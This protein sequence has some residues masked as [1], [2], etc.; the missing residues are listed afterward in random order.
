[1]KIADGVEMLELHLN[2][3]GREG[4][5]HPTL[6]WDKDTVILVDTGIPGQ[7]QEIREAMAN[8][9]VPF[10]RLNKIILT[11][12]D[13][14][15]FGG[16]RNILNE[17]TN[18]V[19]V[20]SHESDK[21]YI[22]GEKMLV[23]LNSKFMNRINVLPEEQR[24]IVKNQFENIPHV[25]VDR[26]LADKEELPYCGGITVIHTPGHTPGHICLYHKLSRTLI[27]GDSMN[28][29]AGQLTGPNPQILD[30]KSLKLATDSLKKFTEYDIENVISYHG[31][32]FNDNPNQKIKELL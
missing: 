15:H 7:F 29:I 24:K 6:I 12:Q 31:G 5:I 11:H 22:Q 18:T 3:M 20:F 16:L 32:L 28:V 14:D 8:T 19:E 26:T 30:E 17:S 21:P 25:K 23:R 27:A 13:F 10:K 2:L 1:M 9:G 4:Y